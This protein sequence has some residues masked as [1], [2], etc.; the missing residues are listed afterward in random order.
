MRRRPPA[1]PLLFLVGQHF[2]CIHSRHKAQVEISRLDLGGKK[3]AGRHMGSRYVV[4]IM[5]CSLI[6]SYG[7]PTLY[8]STGSFSN[9]PIAVQASP[10]RLPHYL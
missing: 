7:Q 4:W 8:S 1:L 9:L 3:K 10:I 2:R 5:D 6:E